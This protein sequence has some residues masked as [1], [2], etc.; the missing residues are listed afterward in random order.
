MW[1]CI[2]KYLSQ[3]VRDMFFFFFFF[4]LT[5]AGLANLWGHAKEILFLSHIVLL[6]DSK[7][8]KNPC[9][10]SSLAKVHDSKLDF[11][12][13]SCCSKPTVCCVFFFSHPTPCPSVRLLLNASSLCTLIS[14]LLQSYQQFFLH[15][16][17]FGSRLLLPLKCLLWEIVCK[18][19]P[20]LSTSSSEVLLFPEIYCA[21]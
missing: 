19:P 4:F 20:F 10:W 16:F 21:A 9:G 18:G 6:S 14:H 3:P 15:L 13:S 1:C 17:L 12:H 2:K 11:L 8:G 7:G 5:R